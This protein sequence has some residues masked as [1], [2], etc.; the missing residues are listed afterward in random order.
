MSK[1]ETAPIV[2]RDTTTLSISKEAHKKLKT[3]ALIA[4]QNSKQF[5]EEMIER[6]YM[7]S[8]EIVNLYNQAH[9]KTR[10]QEKA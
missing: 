2:K 7:S 10:E 9:C 6:R 1:R 4:E 3:L 8:E 5:V